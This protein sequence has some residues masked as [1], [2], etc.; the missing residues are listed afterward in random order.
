MEAVIWTDVL[1][2]VVL[3]GGMLTGLILVV[4]DTG[5]ITAVIEQASAQGKLEMFHWNLSWTEMATWSLML[6][7]FALQWGPYTTDQAVVQRY[8]T[9]KDEAAAARGIWLNGLLSIPFGFVFFALGTCFYL[10]FKANPGELLVG[11]PDDQV[12]PLFVATRMPDGV[13]GL[14]IA[15]IF[16]ASM[17]SL[18]SSLHSVATAVTTDFYRRF[19]TGATDRQCLNLARGVVIGLGALAIVTASLLA[20][21]DVGSLFFFFQK[22]LGLISS[23]LVGVFILAVLTRRA[24]AAGALAGAVTSTVTLAL[25]ARTDLYF[26]LYAVVGIGVCLAVGYAV[27]LATGGTRRDIDGLTLYTIHRHDESRFQQ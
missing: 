14:V 12:F 10:Y 8:M 20:A 7:A 16:A 21:T 3:W 5:G 25:I 27:S 6:G 15:G 17:S 26:Y 18:D 19:K 4:M 22:V 2:T 9:T 11:M 1:Q 13:S 23:G 24:N